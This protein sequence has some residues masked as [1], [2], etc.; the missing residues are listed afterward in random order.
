[1]KEKEEKELR[2]LMIKNARLAGTYRGLLEGLMCQSRRNG[3][4]YVI[5][6][7]AFDKVQKAVER[8][9]S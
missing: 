8:L 9:G 4:S 2:E 7:K 1:V 5:D 3:D 6:A